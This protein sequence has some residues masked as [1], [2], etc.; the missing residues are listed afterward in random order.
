MLSAFALFHFL[1]LGV[2]YLFDNMMAFVTT[3]DSV[4]MAQNYLLGANVLGFLLYPAAGRWIKEGS[5]QIAAF[6]ATLAGVICV[7]VMWQH[8]SYVLILFAGCIDFVLLGIAGGSVYYRIS[9]LC[10][11]GRHLAKLVGISYAAGVLLQF[12][13]NNIVRNDMAESIVLACLGAVFAL[14]LLKADAEGEKE[15]TASNEDRKP[16]HPAVVGGALIAAV[17]LMACIFSTL[18]NAV[19]LVHAAGEADI[20]QWPRILLGISSIAAG[21]LYDIKGRKYMG[22]MMHCVAFLSTL[23]IIILRCNGPFLAGLLVFYLSAG[24]FV[25]FFAVGFMDISSFMKQPKLWAGLGRV[26]NSICAFVTGTFSVRMLAAENDLTAMVGALFLFV[27]ISIAF[28]IYAMQF[29][30]GTAR[31]EESETTREEITAV[32]MSEEEKFAAFTRVFCLTEREMEVLHVL[33]VSDENVQDIAEALS[34]S[35]AAL[36]RHIAG[37]NEKTGTKSRIGLLQFYYSWKEKEN[38]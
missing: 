10:I 9:R 31:K 23:C 28:F 34:I 20:G 1:F 8:A 27:F 17:I 5:R 26:L 29:G 22:V 36:Y 37:L 25:V 2:E 21:F 32:L 30:K 14:L 7:F 15:D 12:L 3:P 35:R 4:V 11:N 38:V 16:E 13:N 18:D 24:F 6:A 33:L 19:T